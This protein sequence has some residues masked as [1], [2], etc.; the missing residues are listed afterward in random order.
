MPVQL[1]HATT[2]AALPPARQEQMEERLE[3][4]RD[5]HELAR[6]FVS[7]VPLEQ[8]PLFRRAAATRRSEEALVR[9][10]LQFRALRE[11]TGV[12]ESLTL[13]LLHWID[14]RLRR[15]TLALDSAADY[16]E[17][18]ERHLGSMGI[19]IDTPVVR[20]HRQALRRMGSIAPSKATASV[21]AR[22]AEVQALLVALRRR[23]DLQ[24]AAMVAAMWGLACRASD[25]RKLTAADCVPVDGPGGVAW[26]LDLQEK[27][28]TAAA[29]R[30]RPPKVLVG[31]PLADA[32]GEWVAAAPRRR[33]V[34]LFGPCRSVYHGVLRRIFALAPRGW[35]PHA[36]RRGAAHELERDPD[37]S[38]D[39]L[40]ALLDHADFATTRLY[41]ASSTA[42]Y[43][44]RLAVQLRR[45]QPVA[46]RRALS[47]RAPR[48]HL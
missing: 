38:P 39:D 3:A 43:R 41:L 40:R 47:P 20:Q 21:P 36:F 6:R 31:G 30:R 24:S 12:Q 7:A 28:A 13:S 37:L 2:P 9:A 27:P 29:G 5:R 48:R 26:E 23:G 35:R 22:V 8:R 44:D 33:G 32:F 15:G 46:L 45:L 25:I 17:K 18:V 19:R 11:S 4:I 14:S 1:A 10:F 42:A 34:G 16:L